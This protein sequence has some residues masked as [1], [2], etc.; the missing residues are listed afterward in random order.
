MDLTKKQEAENKIQELKKQMEEQ[1]AIIDSLTPKP[2]TER[3]NGIDDIYKELNVHPKNDIVK[4]EGFDDGDNECLLNLIAWMRTCKVYNAGQIPTR[5]DERHIPV[6]DVSSPSGFVLS[7]TGYSFNYSYTR[8]G[9]RLSFVSKKV[10]EHYWKC[11]K[12]NR[13]KIISR[14]K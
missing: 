10:A 9:A 7:S 6:Y 12:E 13:I 2:V 14:P 11:F 8:V 1:Q 3:I 4:V 5:K